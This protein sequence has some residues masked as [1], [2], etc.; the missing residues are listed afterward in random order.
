MSSSVEEA[1]EEYLVK[2]APGFMAVLNSV[3]QKLYGMPYAKLVISSPSS[4]YKL[5][6]ELYGKR[7]DT[8]AKLLLILPLIRIQKEHEQQPIN[9]ILDLVKKGDDDTVLSLLGL[10]P[11][12]RPSITAM[13]SITLEEKLFKEIISCAI[14]VEKLAA[15]AYS[16]LARYLNEPH[17][18]ALYYISAESSIH[19]RIYS[20]IFSTLYRDEQPVCKRAQTVP[21]IQ[22]LKNII[23]LSPENTA[24]DIKTIINKLRFMATLEN[25]VDAEYFMIL[26]SP[27]LHKVLREP[28]KTIYGSV[29]EA[30]V[31]DEEDHKRIVSNIVNRLERKMIEQ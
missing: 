13:R 25:D 31:R 17:S 4:A 14:E 26:V 24:P 2:H 29:L 28:Y 3:S 6:L 15:E 10:Q 1:I 9:Q 7:A 11:A 16:R 22:E 21:F 8:A 27:V 20:K 19:A 30:I 12:E 18:T 5:L 23:T